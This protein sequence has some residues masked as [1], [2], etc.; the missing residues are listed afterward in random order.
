MTPT[1]EQVAAIA[2]DLV[3]P[4][5]DPLFSGC[6]RDHQEKLIYHARDVQRTG[7]VGDDFERKVAEVLANPEAAIEAIKAKYEIAEGAIAGAAILRQLVP[8][9]TLE[10][11]S[12]AN[13]AIAQLDPV[14]ASFPD[15]DAPPTNPLPKL[16]AAKAAPEPAEEKP[17]KTKRGK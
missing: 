17:A 10:E 9:G 2:W 12:A 5:D 4:D 13:D 16:K 1:I 8:N 3:K 7:I 11:V 15:L 6:H 14:I